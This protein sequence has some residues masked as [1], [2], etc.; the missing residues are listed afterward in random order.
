MAGM[1]LGLAAW[2]QAARAPSTGKAWVGWVESPRLYRAAQ[3]VL[4]GSATFDY[5]ETADGMGS[6]PILRL[7][8]ANAGTSGTVAM[9]FS[10]AF[11]EAGWAKFMG[12]HNLVGVI[13]VNAGADVLVGAAAGYLARHGPRWRV[14]GTALLVAQALAHIAGGRSWIGLSGRIAAPYVAYD[15]VWEP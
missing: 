15:P 2:G 14:L 1:L 9:N 3:E 12:R 7:T 5:V 11:A 8:V 10:G 6:P 13:A 4:V